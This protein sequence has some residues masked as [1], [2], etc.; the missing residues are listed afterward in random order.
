MVLD[1]D[2]A[3]FPSVNELILAEPFI[4]DHHTIVRCLV[5]I[6]NVLKAELHLLVLTA[7]S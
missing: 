7:E 5:E 3:F 4:S 6:K 1:S 2:A